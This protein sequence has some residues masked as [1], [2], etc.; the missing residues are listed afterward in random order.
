MLTRKRWHNLMQA[1]PIDE[2][3]GSLTSFSSGGAYTD[4]VYTPVIKKTLPTEPAITEQSAPAVTKPV[5][6]I[7][8]ITKP[9][10]V[11][12]VSTPPPVPIYTEPAVQQVSAP[13]VTK[14]VDY[15]P[16][17]TTPVPTPI[18]T[19]PVLKPVSLAPDNAIY[20]SVEV[21]SAPA[22]TKPV[23]YVPI[24]TTPTPTPIVVTGSSNIDYGSSE[25]ASAPAVQKPV[26]YVPIITEPVPVAMGST[27]E[28]YTPSVSV[29]QDAPV[30]ETVNQ[31]A[32]DQPVSSGENNLGI[33]TPSTQQE[34][35]QPYSQPVSNV[36][37]SSAI[38]I[39]DLS[40][41]NHFGII[42]P[43]AG[44]LLSGE[45]LPGSTISGSSDMGGGGGGAPEDG[46]Q[47]LEDT[48]PKKMSIGVIAGI[49]LIGGLILYG[50]NGKK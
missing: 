3:Y 33:I 9:V 13:A 43:S 15:V 20:D 26:D 22:V 18:I 28:I 21:A 45:L 38:M 8:I 44:S 6:Y 47:P 7:P 46:T 32:I 10:P 49:L 41:D 16:I 50:I 48:G 12:I 29:M 30:T 42:T 5:D 25:V 39:T 14:P 27:P 37:S 4:D 2:S 36:P 11:P 24:I 17:I 1:L 31:P 34:T 19:E 35:P 40:G 23:D